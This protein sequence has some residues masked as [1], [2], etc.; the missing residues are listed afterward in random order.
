MKSA[1]TWKSSYGIPPAPGAGPA[2]G[3][4]RR[5]M[6]SSSGQRS[7]VPSKAWGQ[8]AARRREAALLCSHLLPQTEARLFQRSA[9]ISPGSEGHRS[10][11][12]GHPC[13]PGAALEPRAS[14]AQALARAGSCVRGPPRPALAVRCTQGSHPFPQDMAGGLGIQAIRDGRSG[15]GHPAQQRRRW[16]GARMPRSDAPKFIPDGGVL[17]PRAFPLG[18]WRRARGGRRGAEMRAAPPGRR[19]GEGRLQPRQQGPQRWARGGARHRPKP[20]AQAR[21]CEA[22][23]RSACEG[24]GVPAACRPSP[25]PGCGGW[26]GGCRSPTCG[27]GHRPTR[28]LRGP[29]GRL[30]SSAPHGT[31][32]RRPRQEGPVDGGRA[33]SRSACRGAGPVSSQPPLSA[34][35]SMTLS[36]SSASL[37][38]RGDSRSALKSPMTTY[39][40]SQRGR[41]VRP[42]S[43]AARAAPCA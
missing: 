37:A 34:A 41:C 15:G 23:G 4:A 38:S 12:A 16:G 26:R 2:A 1:P 32:L 21:R 11:G 10:V 14:E 40:A 29:T 22:A 18:R 20:G 33:L 36:E 25:R 43:S 39:S 3:K 7:C 5:A 6:R 9:A 27:S 31:S 42:T 30:A 8:E 24:R 17:P 19:A 35:H 13:Q 28:E